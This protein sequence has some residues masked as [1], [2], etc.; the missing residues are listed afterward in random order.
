MGA[1][2][3]GLSAFRKLLEHLPADARLAYVLIPHLDPSHPSIMSD[4]LSRTTPMPV[5]EAQD[6]LPVEADHAYVISPNT[7]MT[8]A[9]GKLRLVPRGL[10]PHAKHECIDHF[11]VSLARHYREKAIGVVLSGTAS[12]GTAGIEA[13]KAEGG[14]T[15][16]QDESAEFGDMPR[17]AIETGCVDF[18]LSPEGIAREL[19]RIGRHPY[20]ARARPPD[21]PRPADGDHDKLF[22]LL[23]ATT[24]VDFAQYK[25][26]TIER[27]IARRMAIHK[28]EAFADYARFLEKTPLEVR[29]LHDELL[30]N[31]TSFFREP[32]AFDVL[33]GSV[34]PALL[35]N[36]PDQEPLRLWI[37][38]C[39]TG[40]EAYSIL[41]AL[42]E[43][44]QD[45][46]RHFD[47]QLFGTDVSERATDK[48][49]AGLFDPG[50]QAEVS[51]ERLSR[52]FT[53]GDGGTFRVAKSIR[54]LC[55]FARQDVTRDPPFS[56]LDLISCRNMLIYLGPALQ[57]RV[58]PIF[59]YALKPGGF[60]LLGSSESV[61]R[62]PQLFLLQ[63]KKTKVYR[64]Q[65]GTSSEAPTFAPERLFSKAARHPGAEPEPSAFDV[66]RATD[67]YLLSNHVPG[68][69]VLN[70]RDQVV[71]VRG[72]TEAFLK[73]PPGKLSASV[74]KMVREDLVVDLDRLI[75][76]AKL[77]GARVRKDGVRFEY[78]NRV[79]NAVIEVAPLA[80]PAGAEPHVIVVFMPGAVSAAPP[81]PGE[82]SNAA[83]PGDGEFAKLK[84]ELV[85]QRDY[86]QSIFEKLEAANEELRS[87]SEETLSANEELQSTNEE[88]ETSKEELQSSNEELTTL[89]DE[90]QHK[91]AELGEANSDLANV[92]LASNVALAIVDAGLKFRR[93]T[94]QAEKLLNLAATDVGRRIT[95]FK[96]VADIPG[97]EEMI[98]SVIETLSPLE[99]EVRVGGGRWC[100][101]RVRPYRDLD[102][103]IRGVV[104]VFV[105][106]DAIKR[107]LLALEEATAVTE[108]I[109][110]T[111]QVPL[112]ILDGDLTVHRANRAFYSTFALSKADVEGR[113]I[114][115][116]GNRRWA[117]A[118]LRTALDQILPKD[119][120][121]EGLEIRQEAGGRIL[122]LNARRIVLEGSG[123]S[124]ILLSIEDV[125]G[126]RQ[127]EEEIAK[128]N[129]G[130]ERRVSERTSEL[131][132]A[133]GE[134]EAFTYSVAHDL[135]SPLRA[136]GGFA[137]ALLEDY[138][139]RPLDEDGQDFARRIIS[140]AKR[141]DSLIQDLLS[142]S[143]LARDE[144][145][146]ADV[147][148]NA[149]LDAALHDLSADLEAK[150]ARVTV[151]KPLPVVK[152]H[153][154]SLLQAV[155]NLVSNA[156][157]FVAPGVE[158]RVRVRAES[159][160]D[161][162][163]LWVEDNGIGV[164]KQYHDR[165]FNVF[166]RL[167]P[168][169]AYPGT[170]IGL[171]IVRRAVERVGGAAGVEPGPGPGS[172][173]WIDLRT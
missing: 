112:V 90:L 65:P 124:K 46:G 67:R 27:R 110:E 87:A 167:N 103:R 9:D 43:Y 139:D 163:R 28:M 84:A 136:M 17:N 42:V 132:G 89:N 63:D 15:F 127:A 61:D 168:A 33:K 153:W 92:F 104:L 85:A 137:E 105:D 86:Q 140:S 135:R 79:A 157:K 21:P 74:L 109:V 55:V 1:S 91:N 169:S 173:F 146:V 170:G 30:I 126:R 57:K 26:S 81:A 10:G 62:Y 34:F 39:S 123:G 160:G 18:V 98:L 47:V 100:S 6:G 78:R 45:A 53:P 159:R 111:V 35:Q 121:F 49:R 172:R 22:G 69:V 54:D 20:V 75:R 71:E 165:I 14:I 96:A 38:G 5:K 151:D 59:H 150:G 129:V 131:E 148:L 52:F 11:M 16:A 36:R 60:L 117:D 171:A 77:T 12:D 88:L 125:T 32:E 122:L 166:E 37:P 31:V 113:P 107:A 95:D 29:A 7:I 76:E 102:N 64:R 161:R 149:L 130:L 143:H 58:I 80:G 4:I 158:S 93:F 142:Y 23:R 120:H 106:I 133:R 145:A 156:V 25:Q 72:D 115:D 51:A 83:A 144:G 108:G 13:I 8:I 24:G 152:A 82:A 134:M 73:I 155:T 56:R 70:A 138:V 164:E 116:V 3:G 99:Q 40:E 97:L 154:N 41:I 66:A 94:P 50:I 44:L 114:Y 162:A 19:S 147:D 141:M 118:P 119:S 48:A 68:V 2:A 101:V 128:L